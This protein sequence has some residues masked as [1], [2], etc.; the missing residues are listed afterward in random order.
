MFRYMKQARV[1]IVS[2]EGDDARHLELIA[3][4]RGQ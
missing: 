2:I 3:I 1:D 4:E